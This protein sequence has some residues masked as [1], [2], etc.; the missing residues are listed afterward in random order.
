MPPSGVAQGFGRTSRGEH[1][2]CSPQISLVRKAASSDDAGFGKDVGAWGLPTQLGP[3][4]GHPPPLAE[5][6]VAVHERRNVGGRIPKGGK[7]IQVADRLPPPTRAV[8]RQPSK[9]ADSG[10]CGGLVCDLLGQP[11]RFGV[12]PPLVGGSGVLHLGDEDL[13]VAGGRRVRGVADL[14]GNIRGQYRHAFRGRD[15]ATGRCTLGRS[16]DGSCPRTGRRSPLGCLSTCWTLIRPLR[17]AVG[18]DP[19]LHG[20]PRWRGRPDRLAT[21][22][23]LAGADQACPPTR[24]T[25]PLVGCRREPMRCRPSRGRTR[26]SGPTG[27][28]FPRCSAL[29]GCPARRGR[30]SARRWSSLRRWPPAWRSDPGPAARWGSDPGPAA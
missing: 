18:P 21:V 25:T 3:Q 16:T 28:S 26:V 15:G 2:D 5:C 22:G 19:P 29:Y 24:H 12:P 23:E 10:D 9:L 27:R 30:S 14:G 20:R 8:R 1:R 4:V 17:V 6:P 13:A 11:R 7:G